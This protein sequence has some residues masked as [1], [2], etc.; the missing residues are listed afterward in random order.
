MN[1]VP[2]AN[3]KGRSGKRNERGQSM[4]EMA[5]AFPILL[6]VLAGTL[7]VGKYFNDYLTLLDATRESARFAADQEYSR[8][9]EPLY[10]PA[11]S[12]ENTYITSGQCDNDFYRQAACLVLQNISGFRFDPAVDDVVVSTFSI[13]SDGRVAYRFPR[14]CSG[15]GP[16]PP[17]GMYQGC[18][19]TVT[20]REQGWSYCQNVIQQ[21][22]HR[23]ELAVPQI[24][25]LGTTCEA[26]AS[27]FGDHDIEQL[28][29][30]ASTPKTG[31]VLVEVYHTHRQFLGLIPPGLPFLPQQ[32]MMHAYTI[33]P[34]P[35][36]APISP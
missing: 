6:L 7:E 21:N 22:I 19:Q 30:T 15:G 11:D 31:L 25:Y 5:L 17:V 26:K 14:P 27:R 13:G 16:T 36:A 28:L 24:D 32:V 4:V 8:V 9:I 29:N 3:Q 35:S 10:D 1:M 18:S 12:N 2:R 23:P 20:S 33:M 34:N